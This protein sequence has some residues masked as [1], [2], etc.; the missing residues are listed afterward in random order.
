MRQKEITYQEA[1]ALVKEWGGRMP[2]KG[3]QAVNVKPNYMGEKPKFIERDLVDRYFL[4]TFDVNVG[5]Q[6]PCPT[7][8]I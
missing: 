4:G 3:Y 5:A 2:R 8:S 7:P 1:K 6:I